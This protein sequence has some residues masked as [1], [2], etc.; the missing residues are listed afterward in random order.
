[1]TAVAA[2]RGGNGGASG[3]NAPVPKELDIDE[4][5]AEVGL[6]EG[7]P[8]RVTV[9]GSPVLHRPCKEITAFDDRLKQLVADLLES[10]DAAEGV[11][12]A[13]NQIGADARVFVYDCP[14]E[15]GFFHVGAIVNPVLL[16]PEPGVEEEKDEEGCLSVPLEFAPLARP[17]KASV[18]GQDLEGRPIRV[19][20][21]GLLARCL[22]HETDHLNGLLYVDRLSPD[23]REAVLSANTAR[24]QSGEMPNWSEGKPRES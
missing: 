4:W 20:G 14:D 5:A 13:A 18:T 12:L 2:Q 3:D 6:P 17:A 8:H 15:T 11:G 9:H 1:V 21:T 24:I 7:R 10:M 19:D 22:Q 23:D 16:P